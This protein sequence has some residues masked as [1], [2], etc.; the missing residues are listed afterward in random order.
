[1]IKF[2]L[3]ADL[4]YSL[5]NAETRGNSARTFEDV[6][7]GM[8]RF[9]EAGADFAVA[10]GDN[11]QPAENSKE[12]YQQ[13]KTMVRK[14]NSY[15][16]PVHMALGNHEFSQLTHAEVLEILQTDR[17]YYSFDIGDMRFVVLDTSYNPD[18]THYSNDNFDWRYGII[19]EEEL[20]WLDSILQDKKRTFIFT[21]NNL[22]FA[23]AGEYNEWYQVLNYNEVCDVMHKYGCVEAVFQT[24]P[25]TFLY[26]EHRGIC[27][28]NIPSP[29]RSPEYN[30]NDFPIV[31]IN[32][33]G[34]T[35]NGRY[36]EKE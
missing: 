28:V 3:F 14:W 34:F 30:I 19:P 33:S 6:K 11:V 29:E 24:H 12:Q 36:L 1:M 31:E 4:H 22:H 35:Y 7:K 16:L 18:G 25:H 23:D 5:P 21:H 32:D 26:D 20:R 2:G 15:G 13:L 8:A 10:L 27:F 9:A 17:T